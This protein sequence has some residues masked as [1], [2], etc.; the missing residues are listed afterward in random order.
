MTTTTPASV[1]PPPP[2][3]PE[4]GAVLAALP[5]FPPLTA[6]AIPF[7]R[8]G[9]A[10]F[11][12]QPTNDELAR[13]GRYVVEERAV[14]GPDGAP[15]VGLLVCR[16]A[17]AAQP[18]PALYSTHGGGM[19][20]GTTAT[21]SATSWTWP[22]R[23][24]LR[25]SPSST[26][27]RRRHPHPAPVEDCYAGL[28]WTAGHAGELGIDPSGSSSPGAAQVAGSRPALALLARDRGGPALAGQLLMCPMLDDRNDTPS[29]RPD[30]RRWRCGTGRQRRRLDGAPR[31][32][33]GAV[34]TCRP[35]PPLRGPRT[36][37]GC[38]R[39]SST[40]ARPRSSGTRT[41]TTPTGSGW[42]A[43]IA[44]LHVWPGGFHG[45]DAAAPQAAISTA[46]VAARA[47]WLRRLLDR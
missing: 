11:M 29:G 39:P 43:A 47:A 28:V 6:E 44:E 2:Y 5:P 19:I 21:R 34:P 23:S 4:C 26:G 31:R 38:R 3:D 25:S 15:D 20:L 36:C 24:A 8:A 42:P 12:P 17:G 22:S 10:E 13:G 33:A 14:P 18:V 27:W 35:T 41:S 16:P 37:P 1:G 46:A 45:F 30:G 9:A 40:S 7:L 32:R